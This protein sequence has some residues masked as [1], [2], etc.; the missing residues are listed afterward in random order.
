LDIGDESLG[1]VQDQE[2]TRQGRLRVLWPG[3]QDGFTP[4]PVADETGVCS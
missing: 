4:I 1:L 2:D 3:Y